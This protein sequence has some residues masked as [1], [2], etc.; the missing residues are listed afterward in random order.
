MDALGHYSLIF[1]WDGL[2]GA[3]LKQT[4]SFV[5]LSAISLNVFKNNAKIIIPYDFRCNNGI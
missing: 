2:R 4:F 5:I 3:I 1:F